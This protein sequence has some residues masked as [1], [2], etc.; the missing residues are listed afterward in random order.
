MAD[1]S[2]AEIAIVNLIGA[3]IYPNGSAQP[4]ELLVPGGSPVTVKIFRGWPMPAV[5]DADMAN[6][7]VEISVYPRPMVDRNTTRFKDEFQEVSRGAATVTATVLGNQVAIGGAV[8]AAVAQF[9]TLLIGSRIVVSY[10]VQPSDTLSSIAAALAAMIPG[11]TSTGP[12]VTAPTSAYLVAQVGVTGV[13]QAETERT[14]SQ[15]QVT[16]WC[17]TALLRDATSKI[18]RPA[19]SGNAFLTLAD[20][21]AAR[22]RF[23][24]SNVSDHAERSTIYRRDTIYD[25]EYPT[26]IADTATEVTSVSAS[27]VGGSQPLGVTPL[28]PSNTFS[29]PVAQGDAPDSL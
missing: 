11:S 10:A 25:V 15:I 19:L 4:S 13:Q 16:F 21:T 29:Y 24:S 20:N 14:L 12:I 7:N 18:V 6:G 5:L 17:P 1:L 26:I 2:D 22:I 8:N 28:P 23:H 9:V 27:I 3:V